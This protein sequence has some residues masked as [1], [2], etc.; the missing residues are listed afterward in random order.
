MDTTLTWTYL[1]VDSVL[2]GDMVRWIDE[3]PKQLPV[4]VAD[5]DLIERLRR[6]GFSGV[7]VL[8]GVDRPLPLRNVAPEQAI[9]SWSTGEWD[10]ARLREWFKERGPSA[11][12]DLDVIIEHMKA[13]RS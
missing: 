5:D 3:G 2:S 7:D 13:G 9:G 6:A 11:D 4:Q 12:A 10:D 1:P 8:T